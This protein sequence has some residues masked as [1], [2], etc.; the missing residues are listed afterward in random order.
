MI[1]ISLPMNT[2]AKIKHHAKMKA[3]EYILSSYGT[4]GRRDKWFGDMFDSL[5]DMELKDLKKE[6]ERV[7]ELKTVR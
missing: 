4:E 3:I 6:V 7:S 5:Y 2:D 1:Q